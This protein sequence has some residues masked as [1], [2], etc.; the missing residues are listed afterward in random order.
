MMLKLE[1]NSRALYAAGTARSQTG[2]TYKVVA[3]MLKLVF[4]LVS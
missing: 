3:F 4:L 1:I 2:F